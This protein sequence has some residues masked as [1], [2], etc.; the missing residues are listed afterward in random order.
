MKA[1][2]VLLNISG[3][4]LIGLLVVA[5]SGGSE[6]MQKVGMVVMGIGAFI[7]MI[8]KPHLDKALEEGRKQ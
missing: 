6:G 8:N 7:F 4:F 5:L 2:G 3:V 1:L